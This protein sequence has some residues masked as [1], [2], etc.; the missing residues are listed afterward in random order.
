MARRLFG[1][2][3]QVL[4]IYQIYTP[5]TENYPTGNALNSSYSAQQR[6]PF[7]EHYQRF[8]APIN[9]QP[10]RNF[11]PLIQWRPLVN[12]VRNLI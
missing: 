10:N 5:G 8:F 7:V 9:N 6:R 4:P 3:L 2:K 1:Q 12:R 11:K